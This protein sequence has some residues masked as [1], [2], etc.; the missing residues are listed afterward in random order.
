MSCT[1]PIAFE[2]LTAYWAGDLPPPEQEA[3]EDHLF[4]CVACTENAARVAAVTEAIRAAVP[5]VIA[6]STVASLRARGYVVEDNVVLP[7]VRS[8]VTF[9]KQDFIIHRLRGLSL[10]GAE[11]VSVRVEAEDTG[12]VLVDLP[13]VPFEREEVLIACQRHFASFP[14]NIVVVVKSNDGTEKRF[15]V[16]H[17]FVT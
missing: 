12:D 4:G 17:E 2:T 5:P 8:R 13:S 9:T 6:N 16:E 11:N 10:A 1:A 3:V 15:Y 14:P 7:D